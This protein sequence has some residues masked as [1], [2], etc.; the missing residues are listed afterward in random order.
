MFT[1]SNFRPSDMGIAAIYVKVN[2]N[3]QWQQQKWI[4]IVGVE[5]GN[6]AKL[7]KLDTLSITLSKLQGPPL[8]SAQFLEYKEVSWGK[9]LD[10]HSL[11]KHLTPNYSEIL[12][13][14]HA[15]NAYDNLHQGSNESTSAYL[16]RAQDILKHIHHTNDIT[17]ISTIGT[18]HVKILTDLKDGRLWNKLAKSKA[19]NWTT[20]S[21]LLQDIADI[22]FDFKRS[23]GY[24][25]PTFKVQ[26]VSSTNSGSSSRSNRQ[27]TKSTQ[28]LL[29]CQ[30]KPKCWHCQGEH[31]KKDSPTSPRQSS[32]TKYKCTKE[33]QHNLIKT[34][35]GKVSG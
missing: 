4:H 18:S 26:Y 16:Y 8:K 33:K 2:K 9:Q 23:C 12:Y 7:C 5:C 31:Y 6:A 22:A 25:L 24:S 19:K 30:V 35:F 15:I 21:Q 20:M 10:R 27:A 13:N 14:T 17:S 1:K 3:L 11:K 34:F 28:Q 29:A 32:P